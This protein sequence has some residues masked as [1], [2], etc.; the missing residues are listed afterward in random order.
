MPQERQPSATDKIRYSAYSAIVFFIVSSPLLY[1]V[2]Q[3][4]LG[5][6]ITIAVNGK[7]TLAGLIVHSVVFFAI[8]LGMM[9][10]KI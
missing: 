3:A 9:H 5:K 2:V 8:I 7:P 6:V 1:T 4:L 10:L